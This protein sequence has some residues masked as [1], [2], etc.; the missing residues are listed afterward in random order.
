MATSTEYTKEQLNY[1]RICYVTTDILAEGLRLIFMQE[2]DNR[3]KATLGEW[4]DEPRN[5]MDF[6][7][8]ESPRN[9]KRNAHLLATMVN[10]NRSEW[11]CT[12]LFYA[13]L[14]SDCIGHGLNAT[15]KKN[16]DDLRK[17]RNEEFAHMPRGHLT[18]PEFQYAISKVYVAFQALG[19]ST[20]QIQDIK[21]QTSF[22]TEE[23]RDVLKKVDDL[24]QELQQ[25]QQQRQV[26]EDQLHKEISSFCI[27]PPKPSHNV[28]GR[29]GEVAALTK[30]LKELKEANETGVSQLYISGNLGSGKSQLAGQVAK[31]FFDEVKESPRATPFVMTLNA[32]SP[33]SLLESYVSFARQVRCP[34]YAVTNTLNSKDLKTDEKITNLKA[35]V[36]A[37]IGFYNPWLLIV[38]NVTSISH[39]H[40]HLPEAGN[41][42]WAK[43]QLLITTQDTTS[44]PLTSSS[45]DHVS[46]S[47]GMELDDASSLLAVL[48][49]VADSDMAREV[50]QALDYQPLALA[51]AATYVKQVRQNQ[52]TSNFGW[53]D[54]LGKLQKGQRCK[55]ETILSETN[56]SYPN[57]MT[58]AIAL[59]V[60]KVTISDKVIDHTFNFLSL[61]APQPLSLDIVINYILNV[62]K[63]VEDKELICMRIKRCSLLLFEED[64]SGVYIRVH[65]VVHDAIKTAVKDLT[66]SQHLAAV[67]GAITSF[68]QF[69]DDIPPEN[70]SNLDTIFIVPHLKSLIISIEY[71]FSQERMFQVVHKSMSEN[72][73]TPDKFE[74]LGDICCEHCEFYMAKK[75]HEHSLAVK[76]N[77]FGPE[78][79]NVATSYYNL[80][81]IH[82]DL[83]DLE[84]AKEYYDRALTIALKKLGPE[85]VNVATFYCSL[86]SI[87]QDLGD[88]EQAKEYHERALTIELKKLGPEHVD[89]A[90]SYGQLG[91]IHQDLGDLEQAKEYHDRALT[92][93]LKN[94]GPE[95]VNVATSYCS[96]GSIH[97]D[98]GDLEQAKESHDRAL[99][100]ELKKLGPEHV[101]VATSYGQLGSIHQDL[102]D[103]EQAKEYHDRALTIRLKKLG[104]EHVNVATSY[105][106]LGSIHQELDDLEQAKEYYDWALTI[107]LKKLGP[108]HVDVATSY[109]YMGSIHQDLDD[110]EEAKEYHD[111]ALTIR[112]KKFGP[113][114]VDVATS[115][116]YLGSIHQD[117]GDLEQAKEYYD[118]ALTIRLKKLGPEH[119]DVATSY[120]HMGS[121]HQDLG[122]LEQAKKYHNRALTID[123]IKLGPEHVNVATSYGHLGSIHQDLGD[124]EQAKEYYNRAL[125]IR[126]KKLG[127]EHV[128]VATSYGQL[129]AIHQDLGDLEQAKEYHERALT[130]D[131]KKLGPEHVNV[132]TSYGH[133]SSIYH[134]LGDLE[135]AKE[136]HDR[137]LA[138]RLKRK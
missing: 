20:A 79:V 128:N 21:T 106:K 57:S 96:L 118:W 76:M 24:K 135:Q 41:E 42:Q 5:G 38:D 82:Q 74:N 117:L 71:V 4:K 55:T 88:L 101:D 68:C 62:D 103:L 83:G 1:Y 87:H 133:F 30:Q 98:L 80:G 65:Q 95:H 112:L 14:F 84:Q 25:E 116:C 28:A 40:A 59:A 35:L 127:P 61:C 60:E 34:E 92:I 129:G 48:S 58:A 77:K 89:V 53:K 108:E 23:L 137:A 91:S 63:D 134:A 75:Y 12:N 10:G 54:Y 8:G 102:G 47:K 72:F 51:S 56:P 104:P 29:D 105:C 107:R 15:I 32:A 31:R 85:H 39:V 93:R 7:N 3:Y 19:L 67:N 46:I 90:T 125:T 33:V 16:V 126:L 138:I 81:S 66:E 115:Y 136:Y 122:D 111:R 120:S 70:R 132:A 121:I 110:L 2:W 22:P 45:I 78:H 119:V 73:Y 131:L 9:Q 49:G 11:D 18:D 123:L 6:F 99:T 100:I 43:G 124:L 27:L 130:I 52:T 37:K 94:L 13:I 113:E 36:A 17:F 44:I 26:L 86:G 109:S 114:H 50:A 97:Q 69:V 64:E